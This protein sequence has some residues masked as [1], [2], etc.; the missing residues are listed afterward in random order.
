VTVTVNK[1]TPAITWLTPAAIKY[2]T[3]LGALQLDASSTVAG[4]FVYSPLAGTVLTAGSH[5]ITT[6]F[7]PTD[8]ADYTSAPASV[9][10]TVTQATPAITWA[11]P[12]AITYGTALGAA[13]LNA[14]SPVGGSFSYSPAAGT[15]LAPGLNIIT[16]TFT[17][18]DTADYTSATAT[19][20]LTVNQITQSITFTPPTA[21]VTFPVSPILLSATGGAS[22][23]PVVFSVVSGPGTVSGTNGST[24]TITNVG[25]VVVVANQAGNTDYSAAPQVTQ[26]I[27]VN[28]PA[29]AIMLSPTPGLSTVLGVSN[30]TFEWTPAAGATLYQLDLSA[31]GP[32]QQDLTSYKGTATTFTAPTLPANGVEVY[33]TLYSYSN[34][35][36]SS[37]SYVYYETNTQTAQLISPTPGPGTILGTS[38]VAFQ[39]T[40][41]VGVTEYQL[42]LSTISYSDHD[43]F[44]YK[45]TA[46]SAVVPTLPANA[47]TVYAALYSL[48][49]GAWQVKYYEYTESGV[50]APAVLTSPTP[51]LSTVLGT[52][53]VVFQWT[54]G[55]NVSNYQL[56]LSAIAPGGSELFSYKGTATTATAPSLPANDVEVYARL[57]SYS[58]G[59]WEYNDY[60][61]SEGGTPSAVLTSPTPGLGTVL[62]TGNV[63]FDWT[64]GKGVTEY[65][66]NLSAIGAGQSELYLYKGTATSTIAPPLPANG[67]EVYARLYSKISGVW[68]YNDYVYTESGMPTAAVLTSPTPGISTVLGSSSVTF[69]WSAGIAVAE[70]ELNL[71]AVAAG[72][73]D[74]YVYKGTGLSTTVA[75]LPTNAVKVYARLFSKISGVWQY[76]DYVYTESGTPTPAALTSPTPGLSTILGTSDVTFEWNAGVAVTDYELNLSAIAAGDTD[77]YVYKGTALTATAPALPANGVKVYARLYSKINGA[78]QYIDY[79]YTEQ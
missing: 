60:V 29:V 73:T 77:L 76:N 37:N 3:A 10:V 33:A 39:W 45:G 26:S 13:Q 52:S 70:Y 50:P 25:T 41:G 5:T 1:A 47:S 38:N 42:N 48:I 43:L 66:L 12:V 78:W 53:N 34:G 44:Q 11:T 71:S 17:P 2:G 79:V 6:T 54:T 46:T 8:T 40:A 72:D 9:T 23:N 67:V 7:T 65:Q 64:T 15:V 58:N 28:P 68:Q 51:G 63:T 32:G 49:Y 56:N 74:L 35:E 59:A 57:Y 27:V 16:A 62:G 20:M 21:P 36:W 4:T 24:L 69:Q 18:N 19:V 22:G 75:A 55:N 14:S 30:V 31:V 61:Y